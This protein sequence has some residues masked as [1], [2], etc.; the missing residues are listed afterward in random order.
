[1]PLPAESLT[2]D[3]NTA[4]IRDAVSRSIKQCVE[5]GGSQDECVAMSQA[6]AKKATGSGSP[7]PKIKVGLDRQ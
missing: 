5:E 2:P 1:M 3:S 6:M 7:A 4:A